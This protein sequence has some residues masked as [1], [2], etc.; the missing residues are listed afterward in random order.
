VSTLLNVDLL[1]HLPL[2][3]FL[4]YLG[5]HEPR[6]LVFSVMLYTENNTDF[7][8]FETQCKYLRCRF[9]PADFHFIIAAVQR[10][11]SALLHD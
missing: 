9:V 8:F 10:F 11:N 3:V 5:K 2:L 1:S 4:H 6:N 7:A